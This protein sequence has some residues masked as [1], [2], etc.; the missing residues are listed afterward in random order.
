MTRYH[1]FRS[2]GTTSDEY[3]RDHKDVVNDLDVLVTHYQET[4]FPPPRQPISRRSL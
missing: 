1:N 2:F 3:E 4:G